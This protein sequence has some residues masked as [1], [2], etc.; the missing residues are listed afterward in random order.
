M[1]TKCL[2]HYR[3]L[4]RTYFEDQTEEGRIAKYAKMEECAY[5]LVHFLDVPEDVAK[6]VYQEEYWWNLD[7]TVKPQDGKMNE[8]AKILSE[9]DCY[10]SSDLEEG[11]FDLSFGDE[12]WHS[13]A[14]DLA[15]ELAPLLLDG[16]I[17]A[18]K[19]NNDDDDTYCRYSFR[20]GR[21][22]CHTGDKFICF[23]GFEDDFAETLSDEIVRAVLRKYAAT[24][25]NLS[26][27]TPDGEMHYL[28][29]KDATEDREIKLKNLI[30]Y[31][32][33]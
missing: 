32:K 20:D 31:R 14:D 9:Y 29:F 10:F 12:R 17:D 1:E 22:T 6:S 26:V 25:D 13:F 7:G 19:H 21:Y 27:K 11:T 8:A 18:H 5:M 30:S 2:T 33:A 24:P 23:S 3:D 16:E 28:L 4:I 15:K